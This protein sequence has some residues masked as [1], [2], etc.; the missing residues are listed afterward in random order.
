MISVLQNTSVK[1]LEIRV[2][3]EG[4][5]CFEQ[6]ELVPLTGNSET[7]IAVE[8]DY[9][10]PIKCLFSYFL[11]TSAEDFIK[12][13]MKR[14]LPGVDQLKI[15]AARYICEEGSGQV[16]EQLCLEENMVVSRGSADEVTGTPLEIDSFYEKVD[17]RFVEDPSS[18]LRPDNFY[19]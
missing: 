7:D 14:R 13:T 8:D 9:S 15:R 6:W 1:A 3:L 11:R 4:P 5:Y 12:K 2:L 19:S 16:K 17:M 18:P 10:S